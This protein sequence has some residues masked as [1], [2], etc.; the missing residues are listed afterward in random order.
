MAK[1]IFYILLGLF[2]ISK[3]ASAGDGDREEYKVA[4]TINL[5]YTPEYLCSKSEADI[6]Q[7]NKDTGNQNYSNRADVGNIGISSSF[8][9]AS[10]F[11]LLRADASFIVSKALKS[12]KSLLPEEKTNSFSFSINPLKTSYRYYVYALRHILV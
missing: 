8:R 4:H 5:Q 10:P 11:K 9:C 12:I 7:Y 6:R 1:Y 3:F 2:L